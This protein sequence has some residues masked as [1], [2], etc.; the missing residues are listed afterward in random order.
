[1]Q[2]LNIPNGTKVLVR[3]KDDKAM[4]GRS[5]LVGQRLA[6][7]TNGVWRPG[8]PNKN[9]L[10]FGSEDANEPS[11]SASSE[12][13]AD[14]VLVVTRQPDPYRADWTGEVH[15]RHRHQLQLFMYDFDLGGLDTDIIADIEGARVCSD[16]M[17]SDCENHATVKMHVPQ[18]RP[19]LTVTMNLWLALDL[20]ADTQYLWKN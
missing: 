19:G 7:E 10:R 1:M 13:D 14:S 12:L 17:C 5:V 11:W 3:L 9:I 4:W 18:G 8:K 20:G 16:E 6:T 2:Q 15:L